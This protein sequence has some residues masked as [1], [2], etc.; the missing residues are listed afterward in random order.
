[1][2]LKTFALLASPP[3]LARRIRLRGGG[4]AAEARRLYAVQRR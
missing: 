2:K 1:M 3:T 4:R